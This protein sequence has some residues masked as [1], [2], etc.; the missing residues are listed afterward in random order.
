MKLKKS[1]FTLLEMLVGI[2]TAGVVVVGM[3]TATMSY[4]KIWQEISG[5]DQNERFNREIV[6]SKFLSNELS[7]ILMGLDKLGR[8]PSLTFRKLNGTKAIYGDED[9]CLYW[10]SCNSLPFLEQD[11]GG[12]TQC[13]LKSEKQQDPTNA[14]ILPWEL[15]LYYRSLK[16]GEKPNYSGSEG[17]TTQY[18][19]LLKNCKGINLGY[20]SFQ[21]SN[22]KFFS[23][24]LFSDGKNPD[25]PEII[26]ILLDDNPVR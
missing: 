3:L 14:N 21:S 5:S 6:T 1:S 4:M 16:P 12:I 22:I 25:L 2:A 23:T 10:E 26:Q 20:T 17:N 11:K 9:V 15:R 24:P 18:I 7:S 8:N 13:W 19:V